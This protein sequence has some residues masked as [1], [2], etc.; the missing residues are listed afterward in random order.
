MNETYAYGTITLFLK[1]TFVLYVYFIQRTCLIIMY[2]LL[3][4]IIGTCAV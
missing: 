4:V 1:G 3:T 2:L